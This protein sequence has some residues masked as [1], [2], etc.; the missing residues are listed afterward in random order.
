M[1]IN[2]TQIE[3][4]GFSIED[5]IANS[6]F[7]HE[8]LTD[9]VE[10]CNLLENNLALTK[11]YRSIIE[12]K[13]NTLNKS[14]DFASLQNVWPFQ[15][16]HRY[17][18]YLP[19]ELR[20]L[21]EQTVF[22]L[23]AFSELNAFANPTANTI[24]IFHFLPTF[25]LLACYACNIF[26]QVEKLTPPHKLN[27][28]AI[29][30]ITLKTRKASAGCIFSR[31]KK[32]HEVNM[33]NAWTFRSELDTKYPNERQ[34]IEGYY[35]G[36]FNEIFFSLLLHE[37]AHIAQD[38]LSSDNSLEREFQ[39]DEKATKAYAKVA[40]ETEM[41]FFA[42]ALLMSFLEFYQKFRAHPENNI[43]ETTPDSSHP[44]THQRRYEN[45][46]SLC[47]YVKQTKRKPNGFEISLVF[48]HS[49]HC[50][51]S[52]LLFEHGLQPL[53]PFFIPSNIRDIGISGY[54][55]SHF[56]HYPLQIQNIEQFPFMEVAKQRKA[57]YGHE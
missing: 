11:A 3:D 16:I 46:N 41:T 12:K 42:P 32:E 19:S 14:Y 6:A 53:T 8:Y 22:K 24:C 4:A 7:S 17:S 33:L 10:F 51:L 43:Y 28:E 15:F 25:L 38:P 34:A 35:A 57:Y 26:K 55:F 21:L 39:A 54:P 30:L 56:T 20:I 5:A 36:T 27:R 18:C 31:S 13:G 2:F 23:V 50:E 52:L 29:D 47:E 44:P 1:I 37:L 49:I 45:I 9:I 40:C 48:S